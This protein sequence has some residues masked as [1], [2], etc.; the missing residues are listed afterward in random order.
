MK[1]GQSHCEEARPTKQSSHKNNGLLHPVCAGFAMTIFLA[2][3]PAHAAELRVDSAA[4]RYV[5]RHVPDADVTYKPGVDINGKKIVPADLN[6]S[7]VN[8]LQ[9]TV[10]IKLTNDAAKLFGLKAPEMDVKGADG[11]VAKT[12]MVATETE[13]GYVT[14]K[15]GR[16]FLNGKP[17]DSVAESSLA[18]LC[19]Q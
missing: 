9:D 2:A 5:V 17:L 14:L 4:C 3:Q 6:P 18:V 13:I 10:S 16:A 12:P 15:N 11:N 7:P 19:G 8:N 1:S